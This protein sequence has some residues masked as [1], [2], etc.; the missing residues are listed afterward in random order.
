M[1]NPF[2]RRISRPH[3]HSGR[4]GPRSAPR[5]DGRRLEAIP[6]VSPPR[7][8]LLVTFL[9]L[10][11]LLLMATAA[12]AQDGAAS[13]DGDGGA[14]DRRVITIDSSGGS[15]SGDLRYGPIEHVHPDP[16]GITAVVS[17]LTIRGPRAVV[18]APPDTLL[19]R[20]KGSRTATFD[21]GVAV[22]RGRLEATGPGLVYEEATGLGLLSGGVDI[23]IRPEDDGDDPTRITAESAEFDVDTDRSIS[24][25][26]VVLVDGPQRAEADVLTY[27]EA[28]DLGH[29]QCEV[30]CTVIR[31]DE[32]TGTLRITAEEIRVLTGQERLW[33]RGDVTVVDGTVTSSGDEVFYDDEEQIAEVLGSPARS[34]DDSSGDTLES[35]RIRHDVRYD[36]VEAID[37]SLPRE[38]SLD[39]F[40]F[41]EEREGDAT[42]AP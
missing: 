17:D 2:Q 13:G 1:M 16:Y 12:L 34:T 27:A 6:P 38:A 9:L 11:S 37:A 24:R 30:S 3:A 40:L 26:S 36:F 21:G 4:A 5:A 18:A 39:A 22:S 19:S 42:E 10:P 33:A 35:D 8:P 31:E 25:G 29:L 7:A 28:R 32:E 23:E 41:D 15:Q 14:E 20:A